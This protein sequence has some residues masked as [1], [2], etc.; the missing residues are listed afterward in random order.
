MELSELEK[1]IQIQFK[2]RDLLQTALTHRS[3]LNENR[4]WPLPHNERLEFL[5]DA[6]LELVTTEYLFNKWT[7]PYITR[8]DLGYNMD[9]NYQVRK[10][11]KCGWEERIY[12]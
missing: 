8:L 2:D 1:Q 4:K 12:D 7:R 3:Y 10:C 6:V 9:A 5:G 11:L